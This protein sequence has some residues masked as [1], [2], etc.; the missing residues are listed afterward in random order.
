MT[1]IIA[2]LPPEGDMVETSGCTP[3]NGALRTK[4]RVH[5]PD[6][7]S[8]HFDARDQYSLPAPPYSTSNDRESTISS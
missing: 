7:G 6:S 4:C 3:R 5:L 2:T 1:L 8:P